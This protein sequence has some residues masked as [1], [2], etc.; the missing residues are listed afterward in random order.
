MVGAFPATSGR[1]AVCR[2]APQGGQRQVGRR[3]RH[4]NRRLKRGS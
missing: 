4:Q 3:S 2:E 1:F